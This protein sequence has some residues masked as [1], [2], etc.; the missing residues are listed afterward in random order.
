MLSLNPNPYPLGMFPVP[1][2]VR[3]PGAKISEIEDFTKIG[4]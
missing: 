3:G 4:S 1:P 2:D